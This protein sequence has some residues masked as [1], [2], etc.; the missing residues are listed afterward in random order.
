MHG[1]KA[2]GSC[3]MVIWVNRNLI[4]NYSAV[5]KGGLYYNNNNTSGKSYTKWIISPPLKKKEKESWIEKWK[6][7]REKK[8]GNW[9]I[10]IKDYNTDIKTI[11]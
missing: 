7:N 2:N 8:S 10:M 1:D 4:R 9:C 6:E 11:G 3:A 5:S